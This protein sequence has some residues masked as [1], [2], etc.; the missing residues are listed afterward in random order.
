MYGCISDSPLRDCVNINIPLFIQSIDGCAWCMRARFR[1]VWTTVAPKLMFQTMQAYGLELSS[2]SSSNPLILLHRLTWSITRGVYPSNNTLNRTISQNLTRKTSLTGWYFPW[3][4]VSGC[5]TANV[6]NN[7]HSGLWECSMVISRVV[8]PGGRNFT[9]MC[10][11]GKLQSKG[12]QG[13]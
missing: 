1:T 4:T 9:A 3:F 13:T 10:S 11:Y 8:G 7:L 12:S 5:I 2:Q 6:F